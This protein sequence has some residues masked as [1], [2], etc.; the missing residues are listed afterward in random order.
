MLPEVCT[1]RSRPPVAQATGSSLTT[2][3]RHRHCWLEALRTVLA[4][5]R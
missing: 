2:D 1:C 5:G 4:Y 3:H